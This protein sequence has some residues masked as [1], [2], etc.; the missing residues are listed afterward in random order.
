M[1][2]HH[3]HKNLPCRHAAVFMTRY[4]GK[5]FSAPYQPKG[6]GMDAMIDKTTRLAI[7]VRRAHAYKHERHTLEHAHGGLATATMA[8]TQHAHARAQP[9]TRARMHAQGDIYIEPYSLTKDLSSRSSIH[10]KAFVPSGKIK[11]G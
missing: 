3:L 8:R 4:T 1:R 6:T 7:P 5:Q 9:C 10:G 11:H 2:P